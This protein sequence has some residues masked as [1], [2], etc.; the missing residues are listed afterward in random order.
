MFNLDKLGL[1]G[2]IWPKGINSAITFQ[3]Y[4][5]NPKIHSGHQSLFLSSKGSKIRKD[6][7]LCV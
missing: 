2:I 4:T 1:V 3:V 6:E 5:K 7:K